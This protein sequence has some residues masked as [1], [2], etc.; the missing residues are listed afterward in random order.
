[1]VQAAR[2]AGSREA[3]G[4]DTPTLISLPAHERAGGDFAFGERETVQIGGLDLG[5]YRVV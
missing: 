2:S 1:M 3:S 5:F 4:F